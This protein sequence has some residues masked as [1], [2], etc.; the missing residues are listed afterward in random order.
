MLKNKEYRI[1]ID[2][3]GTKMAAV[4]WDGKKVIDEYTLAT[5]KENLDQLLVMLKALMDP[6]FERARKDKRNVVAVGLGVPAVLDSKR[7]TCLGAPN[8]KFVE[9]VKLAEVLSKQ[10]G[11]PVAMDNDVNC[12]TRA[13]MLFGAGEGYDNGYGLTIGTGIGGAW[14][15]GGQIYSGAHGG[16]GE[17]GEMIIEFSSKMILEEA[18]HKL[19][20]NNP[21]NLA[22]EAFRGDV[23]AD[24]IFQ[25][26][27]DMMG[28][29]IAN[30]INLIDP[31]IIILGGGVMESGELFFNRVKKTAKEHIFSSEAKKEIKI[32][33]SK[34]GVRAG[35]IGAGVLSIGN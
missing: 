21:A 26:L 23:L 5:P 3:G 31:Q 22:E 17:P 35:A 15:F 27:G 14:H 9:G 4:L 29:A 8:L 30:I 6:L 19:T 25:E 33:R 12:F 24:K 34:L 32:V 7:E 2:I 20:Q 13:E 16:G 11:L 1:G 28:K 18:Y 10:I